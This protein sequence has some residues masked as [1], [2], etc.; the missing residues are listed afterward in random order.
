MSCS[1]ADDFCW[2]DEFC[3]PSLG[4]WGLFWRGQQGLQGR[5][6]LPGGVPEPACACLHLQEVG[7]GSC[8]GSW[9]SPLRLGGLGRWPWSTCLAGRGGC[10]LARLPRENGCTGVLLLWLGL[11]EGVGEGLLRGGHGQW[12]GRLAKHAFVCQSNFRS[13]GD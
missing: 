4:G 11:G 6:G 8:R 9:R 13:Q 2:A 1:C 12:V 5:P 10:D 3:W 7:G